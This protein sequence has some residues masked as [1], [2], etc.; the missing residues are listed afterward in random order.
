MLTSIEIDQ[1]RNILMTSCTKRNHLSHVNNVIE[2]TIEFNSRIKADRKDRLMLN[3]TLLEVG[4]NIS[5][6]DNIPEL[7]RWIESC[8]SLLQEASN[9][10]LL[11]SINR[12]M[13]RNTTC[14]MNGKKEVA[15]LLD[16]S[17][18][19]SNKFAYWKPTFDFLYWTCRDSVDVDG[20]LQ[21]I[22]TFIDR[23]EDNEIQCYGSSVV[24]AIEE[25]ANSGVK[26]S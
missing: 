21:T 11:A 20:V 23:L 1:I 15:Q 10:A 13:N 3:R 24:H 2:A 16:R 26:C 5:Q 9:I 18:H 7:K 17:T 4:L 12:V 6:T 8:P 22:R 25:Y 19:Y 14:L